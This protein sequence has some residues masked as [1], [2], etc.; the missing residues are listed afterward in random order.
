MG[1]KWPWPQLPRLRLD[2]MRSGVAW[3]VPWPQ[4]PRLRLDGE[5]SA[6]PVGL[7]DAGLLDWES[8]RRLL[9]TCSGKLEKVAVGGLEGQ[10]THYQWQNRSPPKCHVASI[11]GGRRM[12]QVASPGGSAESTTSSLWRLRWFPGSS[13][14][15]RSRVHSLLLHSQA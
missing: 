1:R 6:G 7:L 5:H 15:R 3:S 14:L 4:L 11:A 10:L 13:L 9:E 12:D 2:G 8:L